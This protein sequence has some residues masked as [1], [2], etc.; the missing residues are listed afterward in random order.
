MASEDR[1][2]AYFSHSYRPEDR[3]LN[4]FF[5]ELFWDADFTFTVDAQSSGLSTLSLQLM[6][7][8]SSSFVTVLPRRPSQEFYLSSPFMIHEYGMAILADKPRLVFVEHGVPSRYFPDLDTLHSFDRAKLRERDFRRSVERFALNVRASARR[9]GGLLGAVGIALP[10]QSPRYREIWEM[11]E[12]RV[13][14]AGYTAVEER[15]NNREPFELALRMDRYAFVIIDPTDPELRPGVFPYVHARSVPTLMLIP[16]EGGEARPELPWL[17]AGDALHAVAQPGELA[18]WWKDPADLETQLASQLERTY[19]HRSPFGS[20]YEGRAYFD[21]LGNTRGPVFVSNARPDDDLARKLGRALELNNIE[22]FHYMYR[23]TINVGE[24]WTAGLDQKVSDSRFFVPL[25]S[26]AYWESEWCRR[27][28]RIAEQLAANGRL[29]M[30]PCLLDDTSGDSVTLQAIRLQNL[31]DS[32]RTTKIIEELNRRLSGDS[33]ETSGAHPLVPG[34]DQVDIALLTVLEE[35]YQAVYR[36]LP[37][38]VRPAASARHPDRYAWVISEVATEGR[39]RPLRVL[40]AMVGKG[41]AEAHIGAR[42]AIDAFRPGSVV[43]VGVA[44]GLEPGIRLGDVIVAERIFGYEYGKIDHGF[45][46]RPDWNYAPDLGIHSYARTLATID[47]NWHSAIGGRAPEGPSA[48]RLHVG[49][50]ASGNKVVDDLDD[51]SFAPVLDDQPGLLAVEMEGLGALQA[52]TSS[53]SGAR[54]AFGMVRGI[55]DLPQRGMSAPPGEQT[56]QRDGWKPYAAEAA[57]VFV[58]HAIRHKWPQP[59]TKR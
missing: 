48:P 7:R 40:L 49:A 12:Q 18:L 39:P 30:I 9:D 57:A 2:A 10:R 54:P 20:F 19:R 28:F 53:R 24:E 55:S 27:E 21:S 5:W 25:I 52:V 34:T 4:Q 31:Q 51:P 45:H 50:V 41:Q 1:I 33:P 26:A 58:L 29:L 59:P 14:S 37:T 17:A 44:G 8:E 35:E 47:P 3:E 13:E 11:V 23:N 22:Y 56:A 36:H 15:F 32:R 42:D 6:M 46:P 43:V 38:P 16:H